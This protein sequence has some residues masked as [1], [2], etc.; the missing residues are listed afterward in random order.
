MADVRIS[1]CE[2]GQY[3]AGPVCAAIIDEQKFCSSIRP[4]KAK[5]LG[6]RRTRC[7]QE[8]RNALLFIEDRNDD[9]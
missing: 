2:D 1:V 9:R 7:I 4:D 5:C 6:D 8:Q 3:I